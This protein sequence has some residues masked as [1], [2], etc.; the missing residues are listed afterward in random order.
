MKPD[1]GIYY[2]MLDEMAARSTELPSLL[3]KRW[4]DFETWKAEARAKVLE[5]LAFEPR[6]VALNQSID[7]RRVEGEIVVEG[8]SYDMP[9]GPRTQG[10]FVYPENR[11]GKLPAVVALHDH[12]DFFYYGKEKII[13][14]PN[15]PEVLRAH[16]QK[17]YDGRG[18]A[19]E[20]ARRGF[21]VLV[22]DTF[23]WGSRRIPIGSINEELAAEFEAIDL[24]SEEYIR[25]Y[26]EFWARN[27]SQVISNT[28]VDS[29]TSW[30]AIFSYEDRR[31]V[32]Y[33][34][35]RPEIDRER[36]ACGGLS[37]GGLRT[38]FLAGLDTRIACAFCVGFMSTIRGILRNHVRC[39][40]G[41]GLLMYVPQL[42]KFLDLPDIISLHAPA[43]LLV[44]CDE[45]DELFTSQGQHDA[46]RRI[47]AIY[48][49][50]GSPENFVGK[51]YPGPHK[52]DARM[53][54]DAFDWLAER[55]VD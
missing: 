29:G 7:S 38:I 8:I 16:K 14:V 23:L 45:E 13:S 31:S 24:Q 30:P 9:Y 2:E 11:S 55:F 37:M 53:Q 17:H 36:I 6:N 48:A 22:V 5:L 42:I 40:L 33:L 1:I 10:Y 54:N 49:T 43:P 19:S 35:T 27:E 39:P 50:S 21:A 12:G 52:F 18:W 32:D 34:I 44:Q 26:N 41:H 28:I 4:Q 15:E 46:Q 3:S 47:A 20:L 25:K 51:F